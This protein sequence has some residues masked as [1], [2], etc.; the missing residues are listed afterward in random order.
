MQSNR[1]R[2][3]H[4]SRES[5]DDARL[6]ALLQAWRSPEPGAGF[7]REVWCRV[8]AAAAVESITVWERLRLWMSE[9]TAWPATAAAMAGVFA[10]VCLALAVPTTPRVSAASAPLLQAHTLAGAY[11]GLISGGTR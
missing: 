5:A 4:A 1:D 11:I 10:G 9:S 7:N 2:R 3:P 8:E 6:S